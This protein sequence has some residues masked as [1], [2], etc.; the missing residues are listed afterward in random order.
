MID[1]ESIQGLAHTMVAGISS[2]THPHQ[3]QQLSKAA[4]SK[5][6]GPHMELALDCIELFSFNLLIQYETPW[7]SEYIFL[8]KKCVCLICN[9]APAVMKV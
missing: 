7:E 2:N 8:K 6:Y 5:L 4:L 3:P 9:E 1:W